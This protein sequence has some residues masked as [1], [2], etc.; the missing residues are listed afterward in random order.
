MGFIQRRILRGVMAV[1]RHPK[2]TLA[3]AAV[4]LAGCVTGAYFKLKISSDQN[5]LFSAKVPF[6]PGLFGFCPEVSGE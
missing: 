6:S 4:V 2:L 1:V 3:I 5:Q